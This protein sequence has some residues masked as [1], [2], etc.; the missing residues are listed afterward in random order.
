VLSVTSKGNTLLMQH[1]LLCFLWNL[2]GRACLSHE[3]ML[4]QHGKKHQ[5]FAMLSGLK[6]EEQFTM[7]LLSLYLLIGMSNP[8]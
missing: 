1:V 2:Q 3:S 5:A 4:H 6:A 7:K 8:S